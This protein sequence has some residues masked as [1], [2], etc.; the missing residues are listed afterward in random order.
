MNS[1]FSSWTWKMAWR[2][3]RSNKRRLFIYI[4]AIILG[5]AAQVAITSFRENIDQTVNNQAKE[6]LGADLEVET[7]EPYTDQTLAFFDSLGGQQSSVVEFASMAYFPK[8]GSTRLS[9]IRAL[10]GGFPFYGELLTQPKNAVE[11]LRTANQALVD[12]TLMT[13]FDI[14]IGDSVKIG[15]VTLPIGGAIEK[16]PGEA[17]AVSL[18]GPRIFIPQ[19]LVDSTNLIQPGSRV[20]YK[21]YFKF[22]AGRNMAAVEASLEADH[23][24]RLRYDTV[25]ERK[26]E[27]GEAVANLSKFLNLIGFIALLL[28]GIGVASAIHVY[29]KRKV[30]TAAILRCLG[31]SAQQAMNIF[32][33]Q[34][35]VLG[36]IGALCGTLL[37]LGVQFMLPG[38]F[39][40]FLPVQVDIGISWF[41][42]G[43]GFLTG[44]GVSFIFALLPLLTLS[45]ASPLYTLRTFDDSITNLLSAKTKGIIYFL[46]AITIAGYAVLLTSDWQVGLF[47]TAGIIIAFGLLLGVAKMLMMLIRRFFPTSWPYVWRQGLANLYRPNN[48]TTAL[49]VSL[50]LGVLLISTLYFSQNML[51][52]ELQFASR[53][54]A[55]NLIFYDIQPDQNDGVNSIIK[56]NG[57]RVIQNVPM[58]TMQID[59]LNGVSIDSIRNDSTRDGYGWA[60]RREYRSTYRDTLTDSETLLEGEWVGRAPDT[61]AVPISLAREIAEDLSAGIGDTLTF[62]VQGIPVK[63]YVGSIRKVDFQRVQPNFFVLFPSGVLEPAPQIFVTVTRAADRNQSIQIQQDVVQ[64]YP[65]ISAIDVSLILSTIQSFIDKISFAIEF[66]ALF[67]IITGL[68][69]LASS[70]IVSRF[71]RIR[72]SVLLRTL[73]AS[74]RQ[75]LIIT[76]VEYLFL[77]L[78]SALTGLFLSIITTWTLSYFYFDISFIPNLWVIVLLTLGLAGLTL[79]IGLLSSRDIYKKTPLEILRLEGA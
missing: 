27:I 72:E 77:G 12:Q 21:T 59:S 7:N 79:L 30:D 5:V 69:V 51:M 41:A 42:I 36:F 26:E 33:V 2:D 35:L 28:G 11:K 14:R 52:N 57:A 16:V 9:N 3:A 53:E 58:V 4:S 39:N 47:F 6:L 44:T 76:G 68:I 23:D 19:R 70:V 63:T 64:S 62:D 31:S 1:F 43:L 56:R 54:D 22:E 13:Q 38:L 10:E 8:T 20:E 34:A 45:K 61:G 15:N 66:M 46:I 74:K 65:N 32:L 50:G 49:M 40:E 17:A 60:L 67:S 48:Q 73:G 71:Q 75:I 18:I 37:G 29:I 55:P 25:E 24:Q 78:L